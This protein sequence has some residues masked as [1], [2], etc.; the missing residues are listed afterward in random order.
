MLQNLRKIKRHQH[1]IKSDIGSADTFV[2]APSSATIRT[3][4]VCADRSVCAT[5]E[6]R[7]HTTCLVCWCACA[8]VLLSGCAALRA[9][10]TYAQTKPI[11]RGV[12]VFGGANEMLPPIILRTP[13]NSSSFGSVPNANAPVNTS[14]NEVLGASF[15]T[16]E[17][18]IQTQTFP[19][20]VVT[21]VHCDALWRED[22]NNIII[23]NPTLRTTQVDVR[24][25]SFASKYFTHRAS[26]TVPNSEVK[27]QFSG[28]WKAKIFEVG[29]LTTP[30]AEARFFVVEQIGV[31]GLGIVADTY[32]PRV[33]GASPASYIL[34]ASI[35]A[36]PDY[37]DDNFQTVMFF[38]NHRWNEPRVVS[39]NP[40][41]GRTEML[42]NNAATTT[43]L[44]FTASQKRFRIIG[45]PAENEYRVLD[46]SNPAF[47]PAGTAPIRF[48]LADL[49]RNGGV[50]TNYTHDG[51]LITRNVSSSADE[52]VFVEFVFDP[53]NAPS[54]QDIFVVGSFN[55]WQADSA[56]KLTYNAEERLYR[57]RQWIR[58]GRHN[59]LY[60][61]GRINAT[62]GAVENISFEECEGNALSANHTLYALFYYQN[63][64][65]GRYD[66]LYGVAGG[67]MMRR[68]R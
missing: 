63:P 40:A 18:D 24:Q 62:S 10:A 12:R 38:R 30:V 29:D 32:R 28:N 67:N 61:T 49:R 25:A 48:A 31:C 44:G 60:A 27:I 42:Y 1:R 65:S 50:I 8:F 20:F 6:E 45:I 14:N 17:V 66:A 46:V 21:F 43:V 64:N 37:L 22:V 15:V 35:Q 54:S 68:G 4:Y 51:A 36:P 7:W 13:D 11:L 3:V 55:N 41:L 39:Q 57:L 56:W 26:F 33:T 2:C 59:Y 9:A 16:V 34:E 47:A 19:N 23:N 58:R 53:E 52:Y 5:N